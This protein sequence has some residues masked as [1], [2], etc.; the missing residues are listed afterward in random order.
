VIAALLK[1]VAAAARTDGA[2]VD[3]PAPVATRAIADADAVVEGV[4]I[5]ALAAEIAA[6]ETIPAM[7]TNAA[8]VTVA[9]PAVSST[10]V[11]ADAA[12]AD[13]TVIAEAESETIPAMLTNAASATVAIPAVSSTNAAADAAIAD[14]TAIADAITVAS[15]FKKGSATAEMPAASSTC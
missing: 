2:V 1:K 5:L 3:A 7:L 14:V 11:A 12:I 15:R 10:N 9:I 13:A 4:T 6:T 8:S